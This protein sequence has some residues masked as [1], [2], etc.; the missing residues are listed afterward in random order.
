MPASPHEFFRLADLGADVVLVERLVSGDPARSFLPVFAAMARN[1]RS[2][3]LDLKSDGGRMQFEA[4]TRTADVVV[5]G[6]RPGVMDRLGLGHAALLRLNPRL[7][8][9]SISGFGQ[10]GSYR[11]QTAHDLSCQGLTGHLA[12]AVPAAPYGDLAGATFAAFSI[13]SA[14][15]ARA[16]GTGRASTSPWRTAWRLG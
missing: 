11:D 1:K 9:A 12:G 14:L 6:F 7:V 5:E 15:F 16:P 8:Y 10:T 3:C 2:I 4:L 13:A